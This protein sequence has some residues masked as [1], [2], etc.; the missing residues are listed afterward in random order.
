[1]KKLIVLA[2]LQLVC[3]HAVKSQGCCSGGGGNP[4]AAGNSTGVLQEGQAEILTTY[5]F[6]RSD[7]FMSRDS[8]TLSFFD[9]LSSNYLFLK[10]DYGITDRFTMSVAMGYYLNRTI[11]EFP[12]TTYVGT[13]MEIHQERV[14]SSGFGDLILFPRYSVYNKSN[15]LSRTELTLGLGW[16]IP[17]GSNNDSTSIGYSHFLNT[18]GPTPFIDSLEIW[19][20]MP[21]T[22]QTTN[23]SHDLMAYAFFYKGW[24]HRKFRVF[25]SALYVH[26]GWNSLGL[27]FG[28]YASLGVFAGTTLFEK[29]GLTGQL[30]GEWVGK[31][32]TNDLIDP[33]SAY[34]ID[35]AST[36]SW[37]ASFVPQIS[38][39]FKH[40][41]TLF[42]LADIPMYQ[43]MS[44]TQIASQWQVTGGISYQFFVK[45][46]KVDEGHEPTPFHDASANI[47]EFKVWG[48]CEMCEKKIEETLESMS[49]VLAA[50]WDIETQMVK[51]LLEDN[52][53]S[54]DAMM[55]T[56]SKIGYDT[57]GHKA[58]DKAYDNL[59][60][61]CK[62]DRP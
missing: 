10:A 6:T 3:V 18:D 40:G 35:T 43:Y 51:V 19:Q 38:Y 21:P 59:H 20:T 25:A 39:S 30:K 34:S 57:V 49:G 54:V 31:M 36:G 46:K 50:E 56:M 42:A 17:L 27:K 52:K 23:G 13:E 15:G 2:A 24:P 8:D 16:K 12:D 29:L 26:R 55:K 4:L 14:E 22:V 7:R 5:Q 53:P 45:K 44:G 37:K 47:V 48:K 60:S 11:L 32:R 62:Y 58:T 28:N 33:L 1:M 61:C 41:V 9:N